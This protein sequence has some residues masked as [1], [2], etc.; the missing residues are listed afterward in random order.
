MLR[1]M[2]GY[3]R[4]EGPVGQ[5]TAVVELRAVNNRQLD[6]RVHVPRGLLP[7]EATILETI[8]RRVFRGRVELYFS[9]V[10]PIGNPRLVLDEPL[11][12]AYLEHVETLRRRLGDTLPVDPLRLL[13]LNGVVTALEPAVDEQALWVQIKPILEQALTALTRSKEAEGARLHDDLLA[14]LR[15]VEEAL[16]PIKKLSATATEAIRERLHARVTELLDGAPVD[17]ARLAHELV[18]YADRSDINE[19][20]VRLEA[21]AA[22]FGAL[23]ERCKVDTYSP[24]GKEIDFLLQEMF[25]EVNTIGSKANLLKITEQVIV[26]KGEIERMREQAQN[27]E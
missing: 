16:R 14:C 21:H 6:A 18:F 12:A 4:A 7:L 19:E 1:S 11:L 23:L 27:V 8:R 2:T 5:G 20:I 15:R 10:H 22:A 26:I 3:G 13:Q 24:L 9:Q 17:E 25:R